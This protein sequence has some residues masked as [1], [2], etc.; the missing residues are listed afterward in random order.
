LN[1]S[2]AR[3]KKYIL[4]EIWL[5]DYKRMGMKIGKNCSIQPG[6]VFDYSHCWLI[7]IGN[8]VTIAPQAYILA[9]DASTKKLTG[10][11]KVGSVNIG[12]NVFIGARV[13][14]MPGVTIGENSIIAAG[15]VVTKSIEKDSVVA[16]SP[17]KVISTLEDYKI[18]NII[19]KKTKEN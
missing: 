17:A 9:H 19:R 14:I 7:N 15:S 1:F 5:D 11:T 8:N 6:V 18:K 13:L 16:G 3:F 4:E 12:D 2:R 10:Y